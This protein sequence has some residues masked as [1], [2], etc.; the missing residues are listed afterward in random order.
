MNMAIKLAFSQFRE[1][2]LPVAE[3]AASSQLRL[4][5]FPMT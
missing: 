5:R 1:S 3:T 2:W 4:S